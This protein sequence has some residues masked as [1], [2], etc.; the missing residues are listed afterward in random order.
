MH[1]EPMSELEGEFSKEEVAEGIVCRKCK[2]R[3]VVYESWHSDCGGYVDYKYT[4]K[5]CGHCWWVDGIDS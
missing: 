2:E 1:A 4:C 3:D 5:T